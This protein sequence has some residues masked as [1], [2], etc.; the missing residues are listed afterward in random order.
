MI[1][2]FIILG[3]CYT[4]NSRLFVAFI[5]IVG[6]LLAYVEAMA[7]GSYFGIEGNG[8]VNVVPFMLLGIGVDDMFVLLFALDQAPADLSAKE[9]MKYMMKTAGVSI[10]ITSIT[11]ICTFGMGAITSI[12]GVKHFCIYACFGMLFDYIN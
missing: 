1:Y 2:S 8:M 7:L 9:K 5:G 10:T 6:V 11:N 12:Q 4:Y 3:K